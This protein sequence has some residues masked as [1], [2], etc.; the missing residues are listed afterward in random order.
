MEKC[1]FDIQQNSIRIELSLSNSSQKLRKYIRIEVLQPWQESERKILDQLQ[2]SHGNTMIQKCRKHWGSKHSNILNTEDKN[3]SN[4][5][6]ERL[7]EK[8]S[9]KC[10]HTNTLENWSPIMTLKKEVTTGDEFF[11]FLW[12]SK[13]FRVHSTQASTLPPICPPLC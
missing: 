10:Y 8:K 6:I 13:H 12:I 1:S 5:H 7:R 9:P 11:F 4:Q 2:F 3:D